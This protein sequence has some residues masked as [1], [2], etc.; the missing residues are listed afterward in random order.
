MYSFVLQLSQTL[1]SNKLASR[2]N[3]MR[4]GWSWKWRHFRCFSI[5]ASELYK[6]SHL[7]FSK[8][9]PEFRCKRSV[10][11]DKEDLED[12]DTLSCPLPECDHVW[13]KV[14]QQSI[15]QSGPPHS[16][17]GLSELDYLMKQSGWKYCPS[18]PWHHLGLA[19]VVLKFLTGCKTPIEKELVCNHMTVSLCSISMLV[20]LTWSVPTTLLVYITWMQH[21]FLLH[22]WR[23]YH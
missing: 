20:C 2:S 22:M 8:P 9:L 5:V 12:T 23:R 7:S 15:S 17:D 11:V 6:M 19:L 1:L 10:F 3:S 18:K 21:P 4:H 13:C 16:C 14:C